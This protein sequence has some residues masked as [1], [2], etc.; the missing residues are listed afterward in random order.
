MIKLALA[1]LM[2]VLS[3]QSLA[4]TT[5]AAI[6]G[7]KSATGGYTLKSPS[8]TA[9]N[10][11]FHTPATIQAAG[12]QVTMPASAS[13]AANAASFAVGA[14]RLNPAGLF[15]G[16][17]AQWLL[18]EGLQWA[19]NSWTKTT[20]GET[21]NTNNIGFAWA[22]YSG[23]YVHSSADAACAASMSSPDLHGTGYIVGSISS[24]TAT[25]GTC[26]GKYFASCTITGRG[27][28][29]S[30]YAFAVC[31]NTYCATGYTLVNG[32]CQP[33]ANSAPA[34]ESDFAAVGAKPLP[35]APAGELVKV[36]DMPV[37]TPVLDPAPVDSFSAPYLDPVSGRMVKEQTRVTPS[38]T[39]A[40][41][42]NVRVEKYQ[43]D[44]G[45]V[46]GQTAAPVAP[47]TQA[48]VGN[49]LEAI[50]FPSDYAR[51]GEAQAA[52]D[53]INNALGPKLD[54]ITETGAD[55]ADPV[56]PA[57]SEFDQAFFQGTFTNLLG[58]QLPTHTSQCPTGSF[59]WLGQT[60]T[61]DSHCQLI[62]DHFQAIAAAMAVVWT[63]LALFI[64][65]SA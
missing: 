50:Q 14:V 54:K 7:L 34:T 58:W 3:G 60:F 24:Q 55:P 35:D 59:D 30:N 46:P 41:P 23:G 64:L 15:I 27:S 51:Q 37:Q 8:A 65:L 56:Q 57:N 45:A 33:N 13:F 44:A 20:Q 52:A 39:A 61:M 11:A 19:N 25:N 5:S 17:T 22:A 9:A 43:V 10:G 2:C 42:L 12:A 6:Q 16:L 28:G 63:I 32:H 47:T 62:A 1:L 40:N 26:T 29:Y 38:A 4:A 31:R 49:Q 18:S 53:S 48:S 21:D 36:L